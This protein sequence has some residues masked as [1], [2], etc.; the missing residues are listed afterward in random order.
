MQLID[1]RYGKK[2]M[3]E[4]TFTICGA[5]DYLAPEIIQGQGHGFAIDW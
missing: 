2:L 3:G 1:F 5:A 4:R